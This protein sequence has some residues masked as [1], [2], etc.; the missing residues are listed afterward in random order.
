MGS[1][2]KPRPPIVLVHFWVLWVSSPA[3][4]LS[5]TVCIYNL[6][7]NQ[8]INVANYC[9]G[10]K[11]LSPPRF[12][13]CGVERPRC[14]RGSNAFVLTESEG[15]A[16]L[17]DSDGESTTTFDAQRVSTTLLTVRG[18]GASYSFDRERVCHTHLTVGNGPPRS[19]DSRGWS[20]TFL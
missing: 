2:A 10:K 17:F 19:S 14:P 12:Q 6:T 15:Q 13:H 3:V 5:K 11:I 9:G 7:I 20:I 16:H 1:R 8:L 4:L 18:D